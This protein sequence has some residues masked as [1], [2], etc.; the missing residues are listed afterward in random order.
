MTY[1]EL[2]DALAAKIVVICGDTA[3]RVQYNLFGSIE[4][5]DMMTDTAEPLRILHLN[6]C[7]RWRRGEQDDVR[8]K[9]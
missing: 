1:T 6:N 9:M 2:L 5:F 7:R 8:W 4:V 3:H